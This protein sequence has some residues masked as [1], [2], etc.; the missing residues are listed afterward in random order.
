MPRRPSASAR[1]TIYQLDSPLDP[2]DALRDTYLQRD[3]FTVHD[4]E[5]AGRSGILARGSIIRESARWAD[6]VGTWVGDASIVAGLGNTT[7]ACVLLLPTTD[8][9]AGRLWA[10]CFGMGFQMLEPSRIVPGL[11]RR[12]AAR[13]AEPRRLRSLTHSRLDSRAFVARTSIPGGDD[14]LGFGAGDLG[15][16]ISRIVGPAALDGVLAGQAGA[17]VEIRGADAINL[18]IARNGVTLLADLE[19]LERLLDRD[20]HPELAMIEQL[21]ALKPSDPRL[22]ALE[23]MLDEALG[24]DHDPMLGLAWPT[25]LADEAVPLSHFALTGLPRG[26]DHDAIPDDPSLSV[27]LVPLAEVGPGERITRLDRMRVQA[28]SD[29][30][31][32]ASN[33]LPARRWLTFE[34]TVDGHRFCLHD[35]RWY[36]LDEGLSER[37]ATR[38]AAVSPVHAPI[39]ELPD[40]PADTDEA[41]YNKLLAKYL[42]GVC[43]DRQMIVCESHPHRGFEAADVLSPQGALLHVKAVDRSSPASHLFAQAGVSTQALLQ[44]SSARIRLRQVVRDLGGNPDHLPA[45]PHDVVL[46]MGNRRQL[47]LESLPSFARMR[48]V[49]L[50]D[51]CAAQGVRLSVL[52]VLHHR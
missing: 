15:D 9:A 20:P 28:F 44:D 4:I 47:S 25:E 45:R 3:E 13:C 22:P 29:D 34:T 30:D 51:E 41:G 23:A 40:W 37:L 12:V 31:D 17:A 21:H 19:A 49:R 38:I 2:L 26:F 5:V 33:A 16:L 32:P 24:A 42:T 50:A 27:I 7:A 39:G 18:P 11:G 14:L 1:V 36:V 46:V 8:L 10:L 43:L 52:T 35:G 6:V 48:L